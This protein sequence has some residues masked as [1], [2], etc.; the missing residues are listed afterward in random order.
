MPL[1][2]LSFI[3]Q[4]GCAVH[5]V[6]SGRPYFWLLIV[7][8]FP[9]V[10]CLV[11][12]VTQVL[13]DMGNSRRL[14]QG[15]AAAK[16]KID[17]EAQRRLAQSQL[18]LA[19]T[20]DNR[21]RLARESAQL[22]D[23][24]YA[25]ELFRSCLKGVYA[26]DAGIMLELAQTLFA[27]GDFA[28][29]RAV[30]EELIARNPDFRSPE[31]HL[32]YARALEESGDTAAALTEYAAL[33]T[34]FPGEEARVRWALLLKKLQRADEARGVLQQVLVRAEAAPKFYR[35]NQKEW[36]AAA[37]RELAA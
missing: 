35:R 12:L 27:G 7:L 28:G 13:P 26:Y 29:A 8:M 19:D 36:I 9:G 17:P 33:E 18:R 30:L 3:V 37:Q 16:R 14:R 2:I 32:L 24:E 1:L 6:R 31:G 4:I 10:G 23:H 34:A 25:A 15:V 22:G 11:Y 5:V 21:L 20:L